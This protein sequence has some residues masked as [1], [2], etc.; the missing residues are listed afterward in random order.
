M[1]NIADYLSRNPIEDKYFDHEEI[2]ELYVNKV[3][4][5]AIPKAMSMNEIVDATAKDSE[6]SKVIKWVV[7]YVS[8]PDRMLGSKMSCVCYQMVWYCV[9]IVFVCL[10][11]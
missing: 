9:V 7:N 10:I 1:N 2:A 8:I 5:R 6:L 11:L 3:A 4:A